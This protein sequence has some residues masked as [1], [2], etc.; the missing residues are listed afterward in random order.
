MERQQQANY[1]AAY[2]ALTTK[3]S[4][5]DLKLRDVPGDGD[6][7]FHASCD[8]AN[9]LITPKL[10]QELR[11]EVVLAMANDPERYSG[12]QN[13]VPE[14]RDKVASRDKERP[15]IEESS[16]FS[17]VFF[18]FQVIKLVCF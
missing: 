3:L 14:D 12:F 8:Q 16:F 6:C 11:E 1:T 15:I 17:N 9:G 18:I 7:F 5:L 2:T 13:I 10:V 4:A